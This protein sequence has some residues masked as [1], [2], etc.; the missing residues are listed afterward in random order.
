V[1]SNFTYDVT[2]HALTGTDGSGTGSSA[3]YNSATN[4]AAPAAMT[5]MAGTADVMNGHTASQAA[6]SQ[7][8]STY[9]YNSALSLT[10]SVSPNAASSSQVFSPSTG[11]LT[12]SV[13]VHG[14]T[15][16]YTYTFNPTVVRALTNGHWTK[17]YKDGFGRD[18]AVESGFGDTAVVSHVDNVYGPC[19]CSPLGKLVATSRPYAIAAGGAI[20]ASDGT[21]NIAWTTYA[22]D[23]LGRTLTSTA[24]DNS[25]TRYLY[26][27]NTTK[28]T[29]AAGNWKRFTNDAVGHLAM[30][31]EPNPA[32]G[33]MDSGMTNFVTNYTYDLLGHL[34]NV[35]MP[36]PVGGSPYTQTRTFNYDPATGRLISTVQPENGTT[37]YAYYPSGRLQSKVDA[38]SQKVTYSYDGYGRVINIDRYPNGVTLDKCQSVAMT[39]DASGTNGVGRMTGAHTGETFTGYS[40]TTCPQESS[41]TFT[42]TPGG[43]ITKKGYTIDGYE[44][45]EFGLLPWTY[46][47]VSETYSWDQEGHMTSYGPFVYGLDSMKRP[48]S[49]TET[50]PGTVWVRNAAYGPAGEMKGMEY[51]AGTG[52]YYTETRTFNK[53]TQMI[54]QQTS[55][56]GLPGMNLQYVYT[57]GFNN[58][59]IAQMN[60]LLTGEQV[61]YTYDSL[62]RL[63][64]AETVQAGGTQWGQSFGYDGFGNLVTKNPT[65]GHTGT[66]MSLTVNAATNRLTTSGFGYDA[67]GNMTSMPAPGQNLL[68]SYDVENRTGGPMYDQQNQ[69]MF[70]DG[71]WNLYG[72]RGERL[73]THVFGKTVLPIYDGNGNAVDAYVVVTDTRTSRNVYFGGRLIQSNGQTVVTD[74]LGSV[75]MT[76]AGTGAEYYPYGEQ[77]SGTLGNGLE[78]FGTY[79]RELGSGLDYANQRYYASVFGRFAT[80]DPYSGSAS[81]GSPSTTFNRY[82]YVVGDPANKSD[83]TGLYSEGGCGSDGSILCDIDTGLGWGES[84][85]WWAGS[86][87]AGGSGVGTCSLNPYDASCGTPVGGNGFAVAAAAIPLGT[88]VCVGSGICEVAAIAVGTGAAIWGAWELGRWIGPLLY[89]NSDP[90]AFPRGPTASGNATGN[91]KRPD[92]YKWQDVGNDHGATAG[93]HWHWII[94]NLANPATCTYFPVRGSGAN[95]PGPDYLLITVV[96]NSFRQSAVLDRQRTLRIRSTGGG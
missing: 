24:P 72:L 13:S 74:R 67:N 34:T 29:D 65:A 58:G 57:A 94:F 40:T 22:Y 81:I 38:K 3:S 64:K 11:L 63:A 42:Y 20:T 79:T 92:Q 27:G 88:A 69:P 18:L 53:R 8:A 73:E 66:T 33:Q 95:D 25:V 32:N 91:C 4:Y 30:V 51:R 93:F 87:Y 75:R 83:P 39:Y 17:A 36:R 77:Q 37:T 7:L 31:E 43:L 1:T 48:V 55:G 28:V 12:S 78:K 96:Q 15:T 47:P 21:A 41:E 76:E 16:T 5:P 85:P 60:D 54:Q 52:A 50:G 14:A 49:L 68:L 2:G 86:N 46:A 80:P 71:A 82:G 70:R 6:G 45:N 61:A 10:S 26:A 84:L 90:I 19:A 35:A 89:K 62:A 9:G 44:S 59:Q 56:S 23:G